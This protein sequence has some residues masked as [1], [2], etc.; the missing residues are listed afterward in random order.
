MLKIRPATLGDA[1]DLLKIYSHYVS[2]TPI[3]LELSPPSLE[4]FRERMEGILKRYP[5]FVAEEE[6]GLVGYAYAG[7]FNF[8]EGYRYTA[9]VTIYLAES[10]I[11]L[12]LG[13]RLYSLLF[14]AL[15][16]R[17]IRSLIAGVT[18]PNVASVRLH[19]SLGFKK[20]AHF[21]A[22]GHKFGKWWDVGYWQFSFQE[23]VEAESRRV[24][25]AGE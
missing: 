2:R 12:G 20:V 22:V 5:W 24:E 23:A 17:E 10:A 16:Q 25:V 21:I 3:T 1:P 13:K 11:G 4:D 7:P 14:E 8:R 18:L 15:K 6:G 19:E 9:E